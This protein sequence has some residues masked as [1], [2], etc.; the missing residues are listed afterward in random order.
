MLAK[1][2]EHVSLQ[3]YN[4][5]QRCPGPKRFAQQ[6]G[7]LVFSSSAALAGMEKK[8][9][10]SSWMQKE[11]LRQLGRG[12]LHKFQNQIGVT[13]LQAPCLPG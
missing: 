6:E 13:Q 9:L 5:Q 1:K 2:I 8:L 7:K 4:H 11:V 3:V 10:L 12:F